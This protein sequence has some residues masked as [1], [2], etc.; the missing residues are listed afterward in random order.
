MA[1]NAARDFGSYIEQSRSIEFRNGARSKLNTANEV[2]YH[3]NDGA[4]I[5]AGLTLTADGTAVA[6]ATYGTGLGGTAV[7]TSDDVAG[8][9]HQLATGLLWECDRLTGNQLLVFECKVKVGTLAGREFFFGFTDAVADA[10]PIAL[11]TTSTFTT[12]APDDFALIG[13]SDTPTSG[14]AFTTGGNWHT[15]ISGLATVNSVVATGGRAKF[16]T[17]TYYTYRVTLDAGGNAV[18]FVDGKY[19]GSKGSAVTPTVPLCATA[20]GTPR[21]TAGS[22]EAVFTLD[23]MY[24]GGV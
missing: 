24:I 5:P 7:I 11:S 10:N 23:Y 9:T 8:A 6:A 20:F 17:A 19:V 4:T 15:A 21:A 3:F 2:L 13:Y 1:S 12:S 14:A 22:S 18:F 16:A